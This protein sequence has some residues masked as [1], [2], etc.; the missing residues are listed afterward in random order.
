MT[1][2]LRPVLTGILYFGISTSKK[3]SL[4][5]LFP[6]RSQMM[7]PSSGINSMITSKKAGLDLNSDLLEAHYLAGGHVPRVVK[8][9]ISADKANINVMIVI[10]KIFFISH[11]F[12]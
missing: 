11:L 5:S 2:K 3:R 4:S 8:A 1:D 7:V 12:I 10:V 6:K 9:L